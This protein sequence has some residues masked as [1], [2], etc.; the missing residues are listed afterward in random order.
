MQQIEKLDPNFPQR[1]TLGL[2]E[3]HREETFFS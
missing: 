3:R 1:A 2:D